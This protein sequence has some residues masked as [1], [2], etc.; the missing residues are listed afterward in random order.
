[1]ATRVIDEYQKSKSPH[2]YIYDPKDG[3]SLGVN[4]LYNTETVV[5]GAYGEYGLVASV[6][7]DAQGNLDPKTVDMV[8]VFENIN[9]AGKEVA[10]N[11]G[12]RVNL[13][14]F[15]LLKDGNSGD[16]TVLVDQ[17]NKGGAEPTLRCDTSAPE[18]LPG[19]YAPLTTGQFDALTAQ[20]NTVFDWAVEQ[21]PVNYPPA[22]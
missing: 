1:M 19:S 12:D 7:R 6:K 20:A 8:S 11:P 16:W 21:A 5:G 10:K 17:T 22:A 15:M 18:G 4:T 2:N 13:Y 9:V 14:G 3:S